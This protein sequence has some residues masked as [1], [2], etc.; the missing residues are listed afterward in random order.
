MSGSPHAQ[1]DKKRR[2]AEAGV[3]LVLTPSPNS[4]R[5]PWGHAK[6]I[7]KG[8]QCPALSA[9]SF[10]AGT[11]ARARLLPHRGL[12]EA[13]TL[14]SP[15]PGVSHRREVVTEHSARVAPCEA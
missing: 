12:P 9:F 2:L 8:A 10:P 4:H 7:T 5:R 13:E 6:V 3:E 14:S 11:P 15:G 1:R